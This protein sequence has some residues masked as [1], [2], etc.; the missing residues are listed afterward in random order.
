M[1]G[2]FV[3]DVVDEN[4]ELLGKELKELYPSCEVHV[5]KF[6]AADEEAVRKVVD[7]AMKLYGQLDSGLYIFGSRK[8][9]C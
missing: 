9:E 8:S 7:E 4:L 6:N 3:C 2:L 5:R 1:K